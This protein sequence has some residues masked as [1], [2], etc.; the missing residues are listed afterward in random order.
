M[1]GPYAEASPAAA[2]GLARYPSIRA[3]LILLGL[4]A[5]GAIAHAVLRFPLHLP[6]R[7]GLEW[8]A[9][10]VIARRLSPYPGAASLAA[11]G[12]AL[13]SAIPPFGFAG[14]LAPLMYLMPGVLLDLLYDFAGARWRGSALALGL[15][16][17]LAHAAR[18]LVGWNA[19]AFFGVHY[20][21]L[22]Q[23]LGYLLLM[24]LAFGLIGGVIGAQLWRLSRR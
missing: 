14:P 23:G 7:H 13:V 16:A 19:A 8:M 22:A 17:A 15:F 1:S 6:G 21:P 2:P 12:A 18:P 24:H 11:C 3:A 20:G 5:A 10:L 9:L 4:G